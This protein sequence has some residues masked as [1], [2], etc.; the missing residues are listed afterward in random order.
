MVLSKM[1]LENSYVAQNIGLALSDGPR[2]AKTPNLN[3]CGP[4]PTRTGPESLGVREG[5]YIFTGSPNDDSFKSF[6]KF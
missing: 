1:W 6:L 5:I 2:S 3:P 4:H